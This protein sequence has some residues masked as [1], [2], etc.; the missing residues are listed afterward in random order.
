M[1]IAVGLAGVGCVKSLVDQNLG[2]L[3]L[4]QVNL[5]FSLSFRPT[6]TISIGE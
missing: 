1:I 6:R 5:D 2:E 3:I 4:A